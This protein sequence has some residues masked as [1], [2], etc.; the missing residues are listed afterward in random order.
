MDVFFFHSPFFI[1]TS[2]HLAS[3]NLVRTHPEGTRSGGSKKIYNSLGTHAVPCPAE[4]GVLWELR[5]RGAFQVVH[6]VLVAQFWLQMSCV[7]KSAKSLWLLLV[8]TIQRFESYCSNVLHCAK[9][10]KAS[11]RTV[12]NHK[13]NDVQ[14]AA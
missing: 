13:D 10:Q 8:P 9:I 7:A 1:V 12:H 3:E 11:L 2:H 6:A 4:S 5:K 14:S